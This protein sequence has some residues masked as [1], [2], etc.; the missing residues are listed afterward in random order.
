MENQINT[1]PELVDHFGGVTKTAVALGY[2]R[3]TI[4]NWRMK[5][6]ATNAL[7]DIEIKTDGLFNARRYLESANGD[8][9][10]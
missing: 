9:A 7:L 6:I 5:G 10:A 3:A 4:Y 2:T 1:L 8:Q